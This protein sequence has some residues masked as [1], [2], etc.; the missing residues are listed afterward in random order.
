[1]IL[2]KNTKDRVNYYKVNIYPTLFGDF[3]IQK[4]YGATH[5][6]KPTN[7]IKEYANSNREALMILLDIAVDK[8]GSGY[9]KAS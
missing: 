2:F 9:L 3:L 4:E 5:Y 7:I 6:A 1:M 8:K